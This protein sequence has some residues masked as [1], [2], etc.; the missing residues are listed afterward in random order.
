MDLVLYKLRELERLY[1]DKWSGPAAFQSEIYPDKWNG[2]AAF[3]DHIY[4]D[5]Y[6]P[7]SSRR[8][9]MA[10]TSST[11]ALQPRALRPRARNTMDVHSFNKETFHA[12]IKTL[13][14]LDKLR[15]PPHVPDSN[16]VNYPPRLS[17]ANDIPLGKIRRTRSSLDEP[18]PTRSTS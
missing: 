14:D 16:T 13:R 9:R 3:T 15:G 10:F 7:R 5:R 6:R 18:R 2:P 12:R 11:L 4:P 1:P 17:G 8:H